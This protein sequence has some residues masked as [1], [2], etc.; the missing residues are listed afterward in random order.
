MVP[1]VW[2]TQATRAVQQ[3]AMLLFLLLLLLPLA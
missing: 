1:W 2:G 3:Q